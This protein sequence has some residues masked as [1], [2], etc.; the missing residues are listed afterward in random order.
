MTKQISRRVGALCLMAGLTIL[1]PV[2][3][4]GGTFSPPVVVSTGNGNTQATAAVDAAG[5]SV[6]LWENGSGQVSS[7]SHPLQGPWSAPGLLSGTFPYYPQ[8]KT[9]AAGITTAVWEDYTASGIVSSDRSTNGTW[10]KPVLVVPGV[11]NVLPAIKF[12]MNSQGDAAILWP[13]QGIVQ[14]KSAPPTQIYA[15]RR[16][17]GQAWGSRQTVAQSTWA[18]FDNAVVAENGDLIVAWHTYGLTC[19]RYRC[20]ESNAALHVSREMKGS[21]SWQDSGSLGAI[22][23]VSA[24]ISVA[25]DSIGRAAVVYPT[26]TET[27]SIVQQGAGQPWSAPAVISSGSALSHV[28]CDANGNLTV[29]LLTGS[30]MAVSLGNIAANTWGAVTPVSGTDYVYGTQFG[31]A[32]SSLGAAVLSW[33]VAAPPHVQ[34]LEVR[35]ISRPGAMGSWTAPQTISAGFLPQGASIDDAAVNAS[36]NGVVVFDAVDASGAVRSIF[37]STF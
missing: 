17:A 30:E 34:A 26:T 32:V 9:T 19:G 6:V 5:N 21:L 25:A 31:F 1:P 23:P 29:A 8:V 4:A 18:A 16:S 22:V 35:A 36:G 7:A 33:T 20:S 2:L 14:S 10:S 13:S 37:A 15:I 27:V 12:V 28:A 11:F 24:N 3:K